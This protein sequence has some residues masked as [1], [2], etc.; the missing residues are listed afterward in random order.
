M[1]ANHNDGLKLKLFEKVAEMNPLYFTL[2]NL[3]LKKDSKNEP[4]DMVSAL[5]DSTLFQKVHERIDRDI[6]QCFLGYAKS[7]HFNFRVQ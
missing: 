2:T 3:A 1:A 7:N 5:S 6:E 4:I